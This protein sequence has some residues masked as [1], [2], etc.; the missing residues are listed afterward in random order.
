MFPTTPFTAKKCHKSGL[1]STPRDDKVGQDE[2]QGLPQRDTRPAI[3]DRRN[4]MKSYNVGP[5]R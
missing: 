2:D 4:P 3:I 1:K 5:P